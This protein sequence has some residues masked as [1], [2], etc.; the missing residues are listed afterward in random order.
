MGYLQIHVVLFCY[1]KHWPPK[2]KTPAPHLNAYLGP[3]YIVVI[4][5]GPIRAIVYCPTFKRIRVHAFRG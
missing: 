1:F 4:I 3:H 2:S 5:H